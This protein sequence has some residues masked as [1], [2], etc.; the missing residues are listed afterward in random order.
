MSD[1]EIS[2]IKAEALREAAENL[3]DYD[4]PFTVNGRVTN[5]VYWWL[6]DR[7]DEIREKN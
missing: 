1:E 4:T 5:H 6:I 2:R 7:A 3:P